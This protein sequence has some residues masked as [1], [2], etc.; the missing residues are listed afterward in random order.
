MNI[1][2]RPNRIDGDMIELWT[3]LGNK[4]YLMS[5]CHID[6]FCDDHDIHRILFDENQVDEPVSCILT[7]T[8]SV[9]WT[10]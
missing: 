10:F 5:V 9:G 4:P 2:L 8:D 1:L 7:T 3:K 6:C